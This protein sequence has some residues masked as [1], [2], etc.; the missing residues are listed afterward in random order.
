MARRKSSLCRRLPDKSGFGNKHC[1]FLPDHRAGPP[2][3][4][5][6]SRVTV[7][8]ARTSSYV[9]WEYLWPSVVAVYIARRSIRRFLRGLGAA[10]ADSLKWALSARSS[11][12]GGQRSLDQGFGAAGIRG[13]PES[14]HWRRC[15]SP[16]SNLPSPRD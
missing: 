12:Q 9:A 4:H 6:P 14:V 10:T 13:D 2:T 11:E 3:A 16:H 7:Q 5:T 1:S 15:G 8:S